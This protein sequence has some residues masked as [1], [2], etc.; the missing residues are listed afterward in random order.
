[1]EGSEYMFSALELTPVEPDEL[2][3]R[4]ADTFDVSV[5]QFSMFA[6]GG[7]YTEPDYPY[8]RITVTEDG[9]VL[10]GL[11]ETRQPADGAERF[12][13]ADLSQPS[14]Y[15]VSMEEYELRYEETA[16]REPLF[17]RKW[18]GLTSQVL[19]NERLLAD[20]Y[21][22][23]TV[24]VLLKDRDSRL[25]MRGFLTWSGDP[26]DNDLCFSLRVTGG[27]TEPI[28]GKIHVEVSED[29]EITVT[30]IDGYD[31]EPFITADE[32]YI[33]LHHGE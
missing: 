4:D 15:P 32:T 27:T 8:C 20:V 22:D 23:G 30:P 16:G 14:Q 28:T 17:N 11:N 31:A 7:T 25:T 18:Y 29:G 5:K 6:M 21:R 1:M 33:T 26:D 10:N 24:N 13:K 19:E 9:L 3:S 12:L 2:N